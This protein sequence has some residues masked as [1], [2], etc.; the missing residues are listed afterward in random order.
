VDC[1]EYDVLQVKVKGRFTVL[2]GR[3]SI[4]VLREV[5]HRDTLYRGTYGKPGRT[6]KIKYWLGVLNEFKNGA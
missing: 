1:P 2:M 4:D 6:W 5:R 3:L